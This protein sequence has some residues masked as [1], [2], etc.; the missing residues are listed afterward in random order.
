MKRYSLLRALLISILIGSN[1]LFLVLSLYAV[2]ESRAQDEL[3]AET[4]TKNIASALDQ[5]IS[6][7]F[8]KID[9]TIHVIVDELEN[10]LSNKGLDDKS[11]NTFLAK[12][13]LRLPAVDYFRVAGADG[14]V[15][16]NADQ[17]EMR[18]NDWSN[19]DFF[20]YHRRHADTT[21]QI[22]KPIWNQFANQNIIF[23]SRR[24]NNPD[25]SFAGVAAALVAIDNFTLLL[26]QFDLGPKG[27][28]ELRYADLGLITRFPIISDRPAGEVGNSAVSKELLALSKSGMLEPTTY[29][30]LVAS[31]GVE[32]TN[33]YRRLT[34]VPI[35]VVVG[36]ASE[37]YL[38]G[39]RRD[40]K[41]SLTLVLSTFLLSL[42]A[43]GFLLHLL[44]R[45]V[46]ES[47]RSEIFLKH[48]SD[49]ISIFDC[50]GNVIELN[51]R[52]RSM[53]KIDRH[54]L[55]RINVKELFLDWNRD[56]LNGRT[57]QEMLASTESKTF[58][59]KL[60]SSDGTTLDVE[61]NLSV[62]HLDDL[63]HI[64]TSVRDI[65]ERKK[66][67][68]QI[69]SLAYYD[70]LTNL[71]NRRLLMDRLGH[72]LLSGDRSHTFSALM[73]LDLDNFKVLNDTQGHD[74]GDRLLV[75]VAQRLLANV[76][77]EDTVSRFGGDEFL[78]MIENCGSDERLAVKHAEIIAEKMRLALNF[79]FV[80][81]N[82][83]PPYQCSTSV[84][85][86]LFRSRKI[87]ADILLKQ[88]DL[89]LYRAKRNGRNAV[90]F[91]DPEMQASIE[92]N[93]AMES[94]LR[95]ALERDELH[96]F[97]QPQISH[98]GKLIGA[99][100]LLRWQHKD[101]GYVSPATFIPLAEECGLILP[102][103]QWVLRTACTQLKYWSENASTRDLL[104]A[105]NVSASQFCRPDFLIIIKEALRDSGADPT[106]LKLELT[107]SVVL[108]DADA[109]IGRMYQLKALGISFSLDDFGTGFSSL[110][111]LKKLPLDQVK[112]DQSFV[113]DITS[114]PNDAAIVQAI[115]A[116]TLSLHMDVIA[117]GVES[118]EQLTFLRD[119][120]CLHYQGYLFGKPMPIQE[121]ELLLHERSRSFLPPSL[122][123]H[124][125]HLV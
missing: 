63:P 64:Y 98:L 11:M 94:A 96:V 36:V 122:F 34:A 56:I 87:S 57:L 48:A 77:M 28:I 88:A 16:L 42:L 15:V 107:E 3:R 39:W 5:N 81:A 68:E 108:S 25:G 24:F 85:L 103:G 100:A 89:A 120:G 38:A 79:N 78:V 73:I 7:S 123:P 125:L 113:R 65:T 52:F 70:P 72:S 104:I 83:G 41:R 117:E 74:V 10:Q 12:H 69:Q 23:L 86:T 114:D 6:N 62:I 95:N 118:V 21:L 97:Y 9:L 106:R 4:T 40:T 2:N 22:S 92:S 60:R 53:V 58:E 37:D 105:V 13:E 51:D 90:Q 75:E 121:F 35:I 29:H 17:Y 45:V 91:F 1:A 124:M 61:A 110:S 8:E 80:A 26:S 55:S 102:I 101:Y 82:S 54:E 43:G 76:R 33:T 84:G 71:P 111:Y 44:S 31:D 99:E 66:S 112:I 18:F 32:R 27:T 116:M 49:G 30:T 115:I 47:A 93:S 67:Q 19:F 46:R 109:V 119:C 20:F 50:E 59:T 14:R